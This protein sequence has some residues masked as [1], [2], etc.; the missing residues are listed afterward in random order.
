M[1]KTRKRLILIVGI[2]VLV[3]IDQLTKYFA[4]ICLKDKSEIPIISD[5]FT[6]QY[7]E[8]FGAAFGVLQNAKKFFILITIIFLILFVYVMIRIPNEKKYLPLEVLLVFFI[9][10]AIGNF[11]DRIVHTYVIDFLY[12]KL[13]DFPIFNVADIYVTCSCIIFAILVIFYYKEDD[14]K[15]LKKKSV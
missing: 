4:V 3:I 15:F 1:N 9:A 12:F 5:I 11:I 2:I 10:G 7:L 8:N 13:I 14:F 6:L